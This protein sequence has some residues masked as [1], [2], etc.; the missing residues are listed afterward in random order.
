MALAPGSKL[1]PY[2]VLS[3]LGAGGMGEVYRARDTRLDRIVAV[4]ILRSHLSD[5]A[6]AKE[7]F[8]RE[9]KAISSLSHPNICHLY[10]VG[11]HEGNNYLVMEHLEG[12]TLLERLCKGPL[13][14]D[15]SLK[16]AIE[17]CEG[18]EK[19]HRSGVLHRD[20]KPGNIMLT[21]TGAKLMDFG[22]AKPVQAPATPASGLAMTMSATG[23]SNPLTAQGKLLGTFQY[24]SPEQVEGQEA[25]MRSDIFSLGAVLY[26]MLTGKRAFEGKTTASVIAAVLER[27]PVPVS[28]MQPTL[29]AALDR[30]VKT[31]LAK[32]PDERFQT[33]HDLK[34][35]LKWIEEGWVSSPTRARGI[36]GREKSEKLSWIAS[37]TLA[38]CLIVLAAWIFRYTHAAQPAAALAFI[39]PPPETHYLAFGFG[40]GPVAV[41]PDG[42]N[43]AFSAIDQTGVI[44]LWMRPLGAHDAE[45]LPGTENASWPFWSPDSRTLGFF[46]GGKLKTFDVA[47]GNIQVL[48]EVSPQ[49]GGAAWSPNGTILFTSNAASMGSGY[50]G[51][52][53]YSVSATG[54]KPQPVGALSADETAEGFPDFLP[55]GKTFLYA[56]QD[57]PFQFYIKMGSLGSSQRKLVLDDASRPHY[58]AGFLLFV[59]QGK[60]FAQHFNPGSDTLS[61]S[62][63]PLVDCS[64]YSVGGHSVLAFQ[65]TSLKTRLQWYDLEGKPLGSVGPVSEYVDARISPDGKQILTVI[66]PQANFRK[67]A[68]VGADLWSLPVAGGV[69][70][71]LTFGPGWKGWS[72]WS[73][74]GKYIAHS[75]EPDGNERFVRLPA[76]GSGAE[77][78]LLKLAPEFSVAAVQDWSRDGRYIAYYAFNTK[79]GRAE[80]WILPLFGDRKPFLA[81]A[82]TADQYDAQFSPDGHWLAYFSYETG[83]PEVYVVPFPG[84]GGKYQ[85]SQTGGWNLRWGR[86]DQLFFSTTGNQLME[87][88]L[89]LTPQSL[90]VKALRPLFAMNLPELT[91]PLF[92]VTADGRRVLAVTPARDESNSIG[93]LLNWT[94]AAKP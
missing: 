53:L 12:K 49:D 9:A 39:P 6:E 1:G 65:A 35:Q 52:P 79:D 89:T 25:D 83:R 50:G 58:A 71:R 81:A 69:S 15:Q 54:G 33:V 67:D 22:L 21:K 56:S 4:K 63:V 70:R 74:D 32:D 72:V 8:D 20:L 37:A 92:D 17:I 91:A 10:D 60:L 44:K 80:N 48:S 45:A 40:A 26:E 57:Q 64:S 28:T 41:S 30:V 77:E 86:K 5:D 43:L 68:P 59:R 84:S 27:D 51:R 14:L 19:A 23:A 11:A 13:P 85:I 36:F 61:G 24:M 7:R 75:A 66:S 82:S 3:P 34:L 55:D 2:E 42:T 87:A 90:E 93:L 47:S 31:C 78:T 29:P 94:T 62:A 88:D 73:P 16:A 76:N 18:L 46:A 38:L